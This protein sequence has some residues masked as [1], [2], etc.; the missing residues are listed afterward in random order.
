MGRHMQKGKK[1]AGDKRKK[2][3][4]AAKLGQGSKRQ[5]KSAKQS[6]VVPKYMHFAKHSLASYPDEDG[7]CLYL[8]DHDSEQALLA[9]DAVLASRN[10]RNCE[11]LARPGMGLSLSAASI[12]TCLKALQERPADW[13]LKRLG[14]AVEAAKGE[15]VRNAVSALNVGKSGKAKRAEVTAAVKT[16]IDF[17]SAGDSEERQNLQEA[18]VQVISF[19][20][21][22]YVGAMSMLE[23]MALFRRR[24]AWAKKMR[25]ADKQPAAIRAWVKEPTSEDKLS[26]A[27]VEVFMEK[28]KKQSKRKPQETSKKSKKKPRKDDSSSDS[29]GDSDEE[30]GS[31][32]GSSDG[33]D[34]SSDAENGSSDG[35]SSEDEPSKKEKKKADDKKEK[36]DK[37]EKKKE[38][39]SA[40]KK[41]EDA[42]KEKAKKKK[43]EEDEKKSSKDKEVVKAGKKDEDEKKK[44]KDKP[45]DGSGAKGSKKTK[46]GDAAAADGDAATAAAGDGDEEQLHYTAWPMGDIQLLETMLFSLHAEIGNLPGGVFPT[47]EIMVCWEGIPVVVREA[48]TELA[49]RV[50]VV[51]DSGEEY[52]TNAAARRAVVDM[53]SLTSRAMEWHESHTTVGAGGSAS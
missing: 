53:M 9:L 31:G 4:P 34:D 1:K 24:K 51:A 3:K 6:D 8:G 52:V 5:D 38:K 15:E 40:A 47:T 42:K 29:D 26:E 2:M 33:D 28:M 27:L 48:E 7:C 20:S 22:V 23:H 45:A 46:T 14:K 35:S 44:R 11:M 39:S 21:K 49:A 50:A 41:K 37:T 17:M 13:G 12:D 30:S 10:S 16:Y 25:N 43:D 36:K 19:T 32:S 18:L